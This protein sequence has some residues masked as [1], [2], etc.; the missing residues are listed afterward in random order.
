MSI[1]MQNEPCIKVVQVLEATVGGTRRFMDYLLSNID[2]NVYDL[3]LIYSDLRDTEF[4]S[5]LER[6]SDMKIHLYNIPMQRRI[7]P[8]SDL[9]CLWRIYRIM[10]KGGYHVAHMHSSKAGFLG[11]I[12]AWMARIPVILYSPHSF[13]FQ[14]F[15]NGYRARI[16]K[17]L[18]QFAA[19]FHDRL[20]PV[21]SGERN[22]ALQNNIGFADRIMSEIPNAIDKK[23]LKGNEAKSSILKSMQIPYGAIV[24]GMVADFRPQKG[25]RYFIEAMPNILK[26]HPQTYFIIVGEGPLLKREMDRISKFDIVSSVRFIPRQILIA[27]YYQIMDI[28]V[29]T[30][31]WEGMPYVILEAMAMGIPVVA[32][33]AVGTNELIVDGVNGFLTPIGDSNTVANRIS[34]I[35]ENEKLRKKMSDEGIAFVKKFLNVEEWVKKYEKIYIDMLHYKTN[36]RESIGDMNLK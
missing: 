21:S 15:P 23:N 22:V 8:W 9:M 30:S 2:R 33:S 7:A 14:Y 16:Y 32:S 11:R 5:D 13:A 31:L 27:D 1:A 12:A 35:I 28:F 20:I 36:M 34:K 3:T 18:E 29:L 4:K 19:L 10:K 25:I 17:A 24:V 26:K 6:F